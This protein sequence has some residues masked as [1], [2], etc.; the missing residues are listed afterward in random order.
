[1]GP[2][3]ENE[4][5]VIG[6]KVYVFAEKLFYKNGINCRFFLEF[7]QNVQNSQIGARYFKV[8]AP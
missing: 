5:T 2:F 3:V 8:I 7:K 4:E 1:M 6:I